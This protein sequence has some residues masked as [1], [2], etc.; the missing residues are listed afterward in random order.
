MLS[1]ISFNNT[2]RSDYI[3]SRFSH[4]PAVHHLGEQLESKMSSVKI[5]QGEREFDVLESAGAG[6]VD[7]CATD[8]VGNDFGVEVQAESPYDELFR[9]L[10]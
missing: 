4:G 10:H 8:S 2:S 6:R 5:M 3:D 1:G 9:A 7:V